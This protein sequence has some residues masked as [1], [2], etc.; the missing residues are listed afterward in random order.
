MA[1]VIKAPAVM[2][3]AVKNVHPSLRARAIKVAEAKFL[4]YV[5]KGRIA[6][7]TYLIWNEKENKYDDTEFL[8]LAADAAADEVAYYFH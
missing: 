6:P 1:N 5:E 4:E 3:N 8:A 7:E 2:I